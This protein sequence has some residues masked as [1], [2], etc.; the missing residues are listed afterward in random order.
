MA[1]TCSFC[2]HICLDIH[3]YI[4]LFIYNNIHRFGPRETWNEFPFDRAHF[5]RPQNRLML[6]MLALISP[7]TRLMLMMLASGGGWLLTLF[8]LWPFCGG[9]ARGGVDMQHT[10]QKGSRRERERM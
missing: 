10:L 5:P 6:M 4:Y 9:V 3:T 7:Q 8:D 2:T 1:E